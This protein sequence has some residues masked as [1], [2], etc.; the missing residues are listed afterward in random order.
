MVI[1]MFLIAILPGQ[2]SKCSSSLCLS[3]F[4]KL[5]FCSVLTI[6]ITTIGD[7]V[8]TVHRWR[9][10]ALNS[11]H[12]KFSGF[13][14]PYSKNIELEHKSFMIILSFLK[15]LR[16]LWF[17]FQIN[18]LISITPVLRLFLIFLSLCAACYVLTRSSIVKYNIFWNI[19]T[20]VDKN[21]DMFS[22]TFFLEQR[23]LN[24]TLFTFSHN[25]R[26]TTVQNCLE[27]LWSSTPNSVF[28]I[29][30]WIKTCLSRCLHFLMWMKTAQHGCLWLLLNMFMLSS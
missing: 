18:F 22:S 16:L 30:G 12:K 20:H 3:A 14:T 1:F 7:T 26:K 2:I 17:F 13:V 25:F 9:H 8:S 5:P 19:F 6:W 15:L 23:L 29:G 4:L 10:L 28:P 24:S 21:R 27:S 11:V